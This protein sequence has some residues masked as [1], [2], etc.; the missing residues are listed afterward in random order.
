M[1]SVVCMILSGLFFFLFSFS[2]LLETRS[3]YAAQA[4]LKLT[5]VLL[6]PSP[7]G[8]DY[9]PELLIIQC[10]EELLSSERSEKEGEGV[11]TEAG[12]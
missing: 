10:Y 11:G 9:R 5:V 12:A 4:D 6:P 7:K 2:L 1:D 3:C 8:W